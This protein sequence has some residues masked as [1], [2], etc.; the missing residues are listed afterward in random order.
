MRRLLA[1]LAALLPLQAAALDL[2]RPEVR[3]FVNEVARRDHLERRWVARIVAAAETKSAILV[4]MN[5]PAERVLQWQAYRRIFVSEQ[6][7]AAGRAF[8]AEHRPLLEAAARTSGVPAE[9]IAAI[10]GIETSYGRITGNYRVLDALAT[11]AFDY[12]ERSAYFRGEL[13]QFLLLSREARFDP[14]KVTGSYAGAM[15]AP[16]FMP[17]SY[18][19]FAR[20]GD[21]D[22]RID[23]WN[24]W[25]DI[26]ASV[27]HYFI[28]HGWH[29]G[30]PVAAPAELADPDAEDL[31][32]NRL[33]LHY[34]L[35]ELRRRGVEFA[36]ALPDDASALLV[37]VRDGDGPRY[38]VGFHNYWVITRY[39]RSVLYA[40]AA[41]ELAAAIGA[42]D[43]TGATPAAARPAAAGGGAGGR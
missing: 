29:P 9:M 18:R 25:A 33:E 28:A 38:R 42:A 15:G 40:L 27:A 21:G 14:L 24:N 39:N 8:Y 12:P 11:L 34:T 36:T 7:I 30:E 41:C 6:R 17:G 3:A 37:A 23:L 5:R 35:G 32:A 26:F 22:G 43:A 16:Q 2:R 13:E 4:A 31:P 1:V 19:S 10:I 20:D